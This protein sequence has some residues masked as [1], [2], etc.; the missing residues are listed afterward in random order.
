MVIEFLFHMRISK[1]DCGMVTQLYEHTKK[2]LIAYFKL[3]NC[4]IQ[5]IHLSAAL[6]KRKR[7]QSKFINSKTT[8]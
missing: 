3:A 4:M 1:T 7:S 2:H 5:E 8:Y 6:K